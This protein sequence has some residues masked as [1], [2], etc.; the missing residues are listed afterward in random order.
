MSSIVRDFPGLQYSTMKK[1]QGQ[2]Y[3]S[4]TTIYFEEETR[5]VQALFPG[6]ESAL[7][8]YTS[9]GDLR[10]RDRVLERR[11]AALKEDDPDI[12]DMYYAV[13]EFVS[14]SSPYRFEFEGKDIL[15]YRINVR[16]PCVLETPKGRAEPKSVVKRFIDS[17]TFELPVE[18]DY[19]DDFESETPIQQDSM[20]DAEEVDEE[21]LPENNVSALADRLRD[22]S[23]IAEEVDEEDGLDD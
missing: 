16:S 1:Y 9:Q 21:E 11:F 14:T 23:P 8:L 5:I 10:A 7:Y 13:D 6:G 3:R 2:V 22:L 15:A 20:S 17:D 12:M 4:R 18:E 19:S